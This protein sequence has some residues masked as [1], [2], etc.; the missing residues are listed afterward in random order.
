MAPTGGEPPST[1]DDH[2]PTSKLNDNPVFTCLQGTR[3]LCVYLCMTLNL[4][5]NT[6]ISPGQT[7]Y[8]F[9]RKQSDVVLEK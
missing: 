6:V 8:A 4:M 1:F 2:A 5:L 3:A 7:E 9:N